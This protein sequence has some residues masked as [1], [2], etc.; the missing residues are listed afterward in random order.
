MKLHL[1]DSLTNIA[2]EKAKVICQ[3]Y[4]QA[5]RD[6]EQPLDNESN[7]NN[8]SDAA[9]QAWR[10]ISA[11]EFYLREDSDAAADVDTWTLI[12]EDGHEVE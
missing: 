12:S 5:I 7:D 2:E 6:H 10:N 4:L 9:L 3:P 11:P 1:K 8:V